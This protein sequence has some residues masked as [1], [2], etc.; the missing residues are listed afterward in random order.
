MAQLV[1]AAVSNTV[2]PCG[3]EGSNPSL[4]TNTGECGQ[5]LATGLEHPREQALSGSIPPLSSAKHNWK[6]SCAGHSLVSKAKGTLC[7][8]FDSSAFRL[9]IASASMALM[10]AL[11]SVVLTLAC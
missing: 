7:L 9:S 1:D 11:V 5:W 4:S 3:L 6:V 10:E 2:D 8:G